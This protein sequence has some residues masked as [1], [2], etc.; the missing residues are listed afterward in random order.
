MSEVCTA[1]G[2]DVAAHRVQRGG[3]VFC[4]SYCSEHA[5]GDVVAGA[6]ACIGACAPVVSTPIAGLVQAADRLFVAEAEL[7]DDVG[8]LVATWRAKGT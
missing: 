4:C 3:R 2:L 8:R 5:A 6:R 7:K 1:C